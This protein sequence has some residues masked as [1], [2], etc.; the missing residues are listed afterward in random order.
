MRL[1]FVSTYDARDPTIWAGS[2]YHMARALERQGIDLRY[3]GPLRER[4]ALRLKALQLAYRK[5][6]GRALHRD[7][8]PV[9]LEGYARQVERALR[10]LR[11]VEGVFSPGSVPVA[12]LRTPLP[13]VL[14]S[15][16]T[17]DSIVREYVWEPKP[18]ERSLRLGHEMESEAL[19]R[20]A[21]A[22]FTS[23]WAA[24]SAV[25]DHGADPAK[26]K[27]V[28]FGANVDVSRT[29]DDVGRMIDSRPRDRCGVLFIGV[30]WERKGAD[31]AIEITRS[32]NG[33]GLPTEL[34]MLGTRPPPGVSLPPHAKHL[35]FIDKRTD[36]G[37][38]RFDELFAS[39][40]F[41]LLPAR[42]EAFGVVLCEACSFG[43]P[44]LAS[45]VGGIS[46]VVRDGVNGVLFEREPD[47]AAVAR[48]VVELFHN[49]E[50]YR[51]LARS[52]FGEYESR[53]NW[54][55]AARTVEKLLQA[56]IARPHPTRV[57]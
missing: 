7:R 44:C 42:A 29:R 36:D 2:T 16:A 17:Y 26:V 14:W 38:R 28:P 37:R 45:R 27:V 53:L 20:C 48:D 35:G 46:T 43:V 8:E 13:V 11:D 56:V 33:Q 52:A 15:D 39:S 55:T 49:A 34:N 50:R 12:R 22:V 10:E 4:G 18:S 51:A 3:V 25:E 57:S 40:H 1:A 24:R 32:M 54:D 19:R 9:V 23:D 30:G 6:L 31:V 21:L 5:L 41:L 47:P